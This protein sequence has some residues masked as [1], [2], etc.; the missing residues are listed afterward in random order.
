MESAVILYFILA[1]KNAVKYVEL[2]QTYNAGDIAL[3]KSVLD[4]EKIDYYFKGEHFNAFE[5]LVRP[6]VLLVMEDQVPAVQDL[7][8]D[9]DIRF[10]G[11][12]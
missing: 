8:K 1:E 10:L 9:M 7:L 6:S 12:R 3:I 5:P 11:A 4:G 2:L